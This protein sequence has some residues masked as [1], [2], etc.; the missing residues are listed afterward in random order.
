MET[1]TVDI[2]WNIAVMYNS[3]DDACDIAYNTHDPDEAGII[4]T[5]IQYKKEQ[6]PQDK[7]LIRDIETQRDENGELTLADEVLTPDSSRFWDASKYEVG[8]SPASYDKQFL[9]DWLKA[10]NLAGDPTI[11]EVP[12]EEGAEGETTE[13]H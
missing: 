10:N 8:G 1:P 9:R 12:A 11:K 13:G 6:Y 4:T 5:M 2:S 3:L 7:V